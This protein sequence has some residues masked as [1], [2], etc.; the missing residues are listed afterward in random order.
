MTCDLRLD[1]VGQGFHEVRGSCGDHELVRFSANQ[2]LVDAD[3]PASACPDF[4]RL[5]LLAFGAGGPRR[6][7][8]PI[9]KPPVVDE[10]T[11]AV[12]R[13]LEEAPFFPYGGLGRRPNSGVDEE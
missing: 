6:L 9:Y 2:V 8:K 12:R 5:A 3:V 11:G 10:R 13:E 1:I 4:R 7:G